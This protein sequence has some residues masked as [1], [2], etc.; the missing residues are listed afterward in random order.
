MLNWWHDFWCQAFFEFA[1]VFFFFFLPLVCF[2]TKIENKPNCCYLHSLSRSIKMITELLFEIREG[3]VSG[4]N[5][6]VGLVFDI[7]NLQTFYAAVFEFSDHPKQK[8]HISKSTELFCI[9][10]GEIELHELHGLWKRFFFFYLIYFNILCVYLWWSVVA[11]YGS[12]RGIIKDIY[13]AAIL[14]D[15]V[16]LQFY[17][18]LFLIYE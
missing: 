16:I 1:R 2:L 11:G 5:Q 4:P 6:I 10:D 14:T 17:S 15:A 12:G 13:R 8:C 3:V 7:S 18:V 9:T